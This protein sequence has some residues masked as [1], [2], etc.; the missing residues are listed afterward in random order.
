MRKKL[1]KN[2]IL[3][4]KLSD[5]RAKNDPTPDLRYSGGT[6][7]ASSVDKKNTLLRE[8]LIGGVNTQKIQAL[9]DTIV[10]TIKRQESDM[11]TISNVEPNKDM[12]DPKLKELEVSVIAKAGG[13]ENLNNVSE[14]EIENILNGI[15]KSP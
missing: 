13:N 10:R 11:K 4:Q 15:E 3:V 9:R 7:R 12:L 14:G 2:F 8:P 5:L 6:I 1:E